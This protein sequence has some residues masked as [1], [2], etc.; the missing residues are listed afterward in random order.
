MTNGRKFEPL[1]CVFAFVSSLAWASPLKNLSFLP[2][3]GRADQ[4]GGWGRAGLVQRSPGQR[5]IGFVPSQLC[6]TDLVIGRKKKK[7]E[8]KTDWNR[9]VTTAHCQRLQG[10]ASSSCRHTEASIIA[11]TARPRDISLTLWC[12]CVHVWRQHAMQRVYHYLC[13]EWC[14]TEGHIVHFNVHIFYFSNHQCLYSEIPL[15][16][17]SVFLSQWNLTLLVLLN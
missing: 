13:L 10:W 8:D 16:K 7:K 15:L 9:P 12:S 3:R 11:N 17:F 4:A 6:G 14:E 1:F 2:F 5:Q